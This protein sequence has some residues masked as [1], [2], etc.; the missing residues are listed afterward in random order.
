MSVDFFLPQYAACAVLDLERIAKGRAIPTAPM[1]PA[2]CAAVAAMLRKAVH[3]ILPPNAEIYRD[4]SSGGAIPNDDECESFIGVPAPVVALQYPWRPHIPFETEE[5]CCGAP[6]RI[7]LIVDEKQLFK[8]P[9]GLSQEDAPQGTQLYSIYFAE[10]GNLWLLERICLGV[11]QPLVVEKSLS[12]RGPW[13]WGWLGMV[14]DTMSGEAILSDQIDLITLGNMRP[15]VTAVVQCC[16]G[17]RA[18]AQLTEHTEQ[19]ATRRRKFIRKGVGDF[20]YHVLKVPGQHSGDDKINSG[21]HASP[22]FH[23][24]RAHIRKLP[25]GVLTFVRQCFVGDS[26]AGIVGKHYKM[27]SIEEAA[28]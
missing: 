25:T 23:I 16:H 2:A 12:A 17:L 27:E 20:V 24:R 28:A 7:T 5:K 13:D 21:T 3:I 6:K 8:R 15:D 10:D 18:G 26:N 22:R 4:N 1:Y 14:R 9:D 11:R 19:S